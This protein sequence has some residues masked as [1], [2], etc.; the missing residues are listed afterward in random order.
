MINN[1]QNDKS[2]EPDNDYDLEQEELENQTAKSIETTLYDLVLQLENLGSEKEKD[3]FIKNYGR[4][5]EQIELTDLALSDSPESEKFIKKYENMS[6]GKLFEL[7]EKNSE[8]IINPK[9]LSTWKFKQLLIISKVLEQ[10][11]DANTLDIV[12][13][14]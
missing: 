3:E 5:K 10:K 12:E 8:F 6:V 11:L 7:M 14:K 2:N 1:K 4:L 13:T 9:N